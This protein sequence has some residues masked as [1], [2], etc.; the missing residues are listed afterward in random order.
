MAI[1]FAQTEDGPNKLRIDEDKLSK[2]EKEAI[3]LAKKSGFLTSEE[4]ELKPTDS[5]IEVQGGNALT[6]EIDKTTAD[7][8][9]DDGSGG[10][11]KKESGFK[12]F[13]E[14][15]G[16]AFENIAD[17]AEK[18]LETVYDDREKRAMFL[19]GLN[20]IID[21]SSYRPIGEAKSIVGTI[22]GGQKK[23]FLESEAIQTKRDTIE[24]Q[25]LA[26]KSKKDTAANKQLID[27]LKLEIDKKE[28]KTNKMKP[29]YDK[30]NKK[31][32]NTNKASEN[33]SYFD[34]LKKLTAKQII[35][36]GQIPVGLIYSQFP[37]GLQAFADV[38]PS[39]LKPDNAFFDKIQDEATY[40]QQVSKLIDSMVLGDIGQLVPVSD[41]D[42]EIKRNTFPTEK[43]SPLA[44]VYSL[45]TQDAINKIN[46]YKNEFLTS[47]QMNEGLENNQSF[48]NEFRTKGADFIRADIINQ[49]DKDQL[50]EE[51]A[52]LGFQQDYD[53]YTSGQPD[54]SPLA[55][56]EAAASIDL[57]TFDKYSMITSSDLSGG[58]K[59]IPAPVVSEGKKTNEQLL[60][61]ATK[62][63]ETA[64]D[65]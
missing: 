20:T 12:N 62:E 19:S 13:I 46:S 11:K 23:G 9:N 16:T 31:Y 54:F 57:G 36:S 30:L 38:L 53:K 22:A 65:L 3:D 40:L 8:Q 33:V 2:N 51:A 41:K 1:L 52:K 35:D 5:K 64:P 42:V 61:E 34:Q 24:A 60:N 14:S 55:L 21:A 44:F 26:A 25:K 18:K 27:L 15:V 17:G 50:Y 45:R 37:K 39:S 32:E 6:S 10:G 48:E 49:Y 43:N 58:D 56:A 59:K 28:A 4:S 47:F 29:I 7:E 63:L